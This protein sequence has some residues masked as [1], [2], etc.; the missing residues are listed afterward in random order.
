MTYSES[1]EGIRI[2]K[3]RA[4]RELRDH[5]VVETQDFFEDLGDRETYEASEVLVWLGY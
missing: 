4:L 5:G 1:A 2:S 3:A